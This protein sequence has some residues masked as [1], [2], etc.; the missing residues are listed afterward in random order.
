[1][2]VWMF[3]A[4]LPMWVKVGAAAGLLIGVLELRHWWTTRDLKRDLAKQEETLKKTQ[5]EAAKAAAVYQQNAEREEA[6]RKEQQA[7]IDK[8]NQRIN[9][10]A[11]RAREAESN[12][13][14]AA[15]RVSEEGRLIA[16]ALRDKSSPVPAGPEG[17]TRWLEQRFATTE[18]PK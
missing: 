16:E 15:F 5:E 11:A 17:M 3:F 4:K 6:N 8:Q 18:V 2:P 10:V 1:M 14:L 9:A 13:A 12:A 7:A